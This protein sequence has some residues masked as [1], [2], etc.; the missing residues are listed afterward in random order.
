M[1]L[2][3]GNA[4]MLL[5]GLGF[6][7]EDYCGKL[8]PNAVLAAIARTPVELLERSESVEGNMITCGVD[9][10]RVNRY[11]DKLKE[12]AL[13]AAKREEWIYWG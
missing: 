13:E 4:T 9:L 8:N 6:P 1:N 3:N 12:I 7:V 11:F 10:D 2:A 5:S